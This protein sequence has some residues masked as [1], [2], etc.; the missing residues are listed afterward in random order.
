MSVPH[1]AALL[2]FTPASI[3]LSIRTC[4]H[5]ASVNPT[6]HI[7]GSHPTRF[8]IIS[9]ITR[10][11]FS[12]QE[13]PQYTTIHDRVRFTAVRLQRNRASGWGSKYFDSTTITQ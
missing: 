11:E 12:R 10:I 1:Q 4:H 6:S 2:L 5:S 8:T 13:K 7:A 9:T 3:Q